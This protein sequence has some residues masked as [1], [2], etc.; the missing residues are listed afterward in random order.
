MFD[1]NAP[2]A[3]NEMIEEW[4]KDLLNRTGHQTTDELTEME[5]SAEILEIEGTISN[6]RVW[7][8]GAET[9]E[10]RLLH[11]GNIHNLIT[12]LGQLEKLIEAHTTQDTE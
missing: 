4:F 5:I 3:D 12:Y 10:Q 1:A 2:I 9:T 7:E 11:S 6:E 8:K